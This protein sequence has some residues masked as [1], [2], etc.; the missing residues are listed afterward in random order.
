ML[1]L[2]PLQW[3]NL[4]LSDYFTSSSHVI[5]FFCFEMLFPSRQRVPVPVS[6]AAAAGVYFSDP[7]HLLL[8][9]A[10]TELLNF[11]NDLLPVFGF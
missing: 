3:M 6:D 5:G 1:S 9:T 2:E 8:D 7:V 4:Y 11:G 10:A